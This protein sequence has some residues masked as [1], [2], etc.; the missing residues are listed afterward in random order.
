MNREDATRIIRESWRQLLPLMA[1]QAKRKVNGEASYICPLCG[2]GKSGDGLT[3]NPKSRDGN[4]LKCFGCNFTGDII[5]LY[6]AISGTDHNTA[7]RTLADR[8]SIAIDP[9]APSPPIQ[10]AQT[11][12]E[13]E[14]QRRGEEAEADYSRYY[15]LCA[16]RLSEPEA[17][18]Y[19]QKR[20]ISEKTARTFFIGFDPA[21]DPASAPGATSEEYKPHPCPRLII[22]CSKSYYIA[23]R[24]DGGQE[25]KKLMPKGGTAAFFNRYALKEQDAQEVFITEAAIDAL[26]IAEAGAPAMALNSAAYTDKLLTD[27]EQEKPRA[28]LILCLDNDKAGKRASNK[29][30]EGL[31]RLAIPFLDATAEICGGAKDANEALTADRAAFIGAVDNARQQARAL[32]EAR[33]REDQ[34]AEAERSQRTGAGMVDAFIESVQSRKYEPMP[35]GIAEIDNAIGGGFIRQQLVLLGAAP[36]AGKTA[37]AQWIFESMAARGISSVY[38]NLE[39]SRDQM[40]ARSLA[41]LTARRGHAISATRILQGYSWTAEERAEITAAAEEYKATIA[42][43]LIYNPDGV[44]AN[45]ESIMQYLT[46]E[47]ERAEKRGEKAPCVILDY[48][49]IVNGDPREDA[50]SLIKRAVITLKEF[51]IKHGTLVFVIIAHNRASNSSGAVSMESG[52]DTSALEYSADLQLA[53]TYTDC[54]KR[55]PN[56]GKNPDD[57]T[58]NDRKRVT[59]IVTKGRFGG[60]GQSIDLLFTG[61]TMSFARAPEKREEPKEEP[62]EEKPRA[63]I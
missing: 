5:D 11:I 59:L 31:E 21:A 56:R 62:A 34:N 2:H 26:S 25:Y 45:L 18:A 51:A 4:G 13:R 58:P 57:L 49:Q 52:R 36:G 32:T 8:L 33:A 23:R 55:G 24:T 1:E 28:L 19:L 6:R 39:M 30:A 37:L 27:L 53:L 12:P 38:L 20:G 40:L 29:L 22:P 47:A 50:A 41:R 44:T 14:R 15:E 3:F 43:N 16:A 46:A 10:T 35:T 60:A 17:Q 7:A 61:E 9:G 63:R 54:L 42:D 48:L